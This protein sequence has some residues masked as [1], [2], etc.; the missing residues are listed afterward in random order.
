MMAWQ[1][2]M[3]YYLVEVD[4]CVVYKWLLTNIDQNEVSMSACLLQIRMLVGAQTFNEIDDWVTN[5]QMW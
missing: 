3:F 5:N 4:Y 1:S 2:E